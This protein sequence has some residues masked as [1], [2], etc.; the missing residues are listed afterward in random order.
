MTPRCRTSPAGVDGPACKEGV[1]LAMPASEGRS[2][3]GE[4][5]N[6]EKREEGEGERGGEGERKRI[7]LSECVFE[8]DI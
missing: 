8:V 4:S 5:K 6:G 1:G 3:I 2:K 7:C